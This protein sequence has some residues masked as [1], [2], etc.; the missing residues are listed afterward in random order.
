MCILL[1]WSITGNSDLSIF[2]HIKCVEIHCSYCSFWHSDCLFW[3]VEIILVASGSFW[4][5][6]QSWKASL[7]ILDNFSSPHPP[8]ETGYFSK[9]FLQWE[10]ALDSS[11]WTIAWSLLTGRCFQAFKDKVRKWDKNTMSSALY[12][13]LKFRI[14]KFLL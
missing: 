2:K 9:Y 11:V 3:P 5:N 13:Q 14:I 12:F 7:L 4:Y 6:L 10:M 8:P 1:Q